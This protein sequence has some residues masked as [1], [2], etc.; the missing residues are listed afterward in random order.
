MA[1]NRHRESASRRRDIRVLHVDDERALGELV[2]TLLAREDEQITVVTEP[3]ASD[4]LARLE[5][6]HEE[7][8]CIVSDYEMPGMDGVEFL[9]AVRDDYPDLP[10]ILFTGKGSEEVASEAI[11]AGATD[12]LQKESGTEQYELLA[13]RIQNAVSQTRGVRAQ[14]QLRELAETT[15]RVFFIFNHD[16]SEGNK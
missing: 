6:D 15:N 9:E 14:H 12:Y 3:S 2:A 4:G 1:K 5:A 13:N 7:I 11:S 10:F 16:W 8:D